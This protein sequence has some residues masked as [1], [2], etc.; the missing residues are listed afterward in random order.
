[1]YRF[2]S[3]F[4]YFFFCDPTEKPLAKHTQFFVLIVSIFY[5]PI[6]T[7]IVYKLITFCVI[8]IHGERNI[9][10]WYRIDT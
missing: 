6:A 4:F 2:S 8:I 10:R 5:L 1:M 7:V 3:F 9:P